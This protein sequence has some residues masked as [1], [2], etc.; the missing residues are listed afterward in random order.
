MR[1]LSASRKAWRS[2]AQKVGFMQKLCYL[3][4]CSWLFTGLARASSPTGEPLLAPLPHLEIPMVKS[5]ENR[6]VFRM[7][8]KAPSLLSKEETITV[9]RFSLPAADAELSALLAPESEAP[10]VVND[11]MN[12]ILNLTN[13]IT[14]EQVKEAKK[15]VDDAILV[16]NFVSSLNGDD[17]VTLPAVMKQEI[18]NLT[19]HLV[20]DKVTLKPQGACLN[21]IVGL[22]IPQKAYDAEGRKQEITLFFG[23]DDILI[24]QDGGIQGVSELKLL[25]DVAFELGGSTKKV[26]VQLVGEDNPNHSEYTYVS[27]GCSGI[28][29]FSLASNIFFSREWVVPLNEAG[30]VIPNQLVTAFFNLKVQDWNDILLQNLTINRFAMTDFSDVIIEVG[31]ANLDLSDYS[32]PSTLTFPDNYEPE[33]L[34]NPNLWRGVYIEHIE[35]TLPKPFKRKC[36]GFGSNGSGQTCRITLEAN[37]MIVDNTGFSAHLSIQN[38][39][40]ILGSGLM[41]GKWSWSLDQV[42]VEILQS[43]V[44][45]FGFGGEI[46]APITGKDT[47]IAYLG[48][49][50]F[51]SDNYHFVAT[52]GDDLEFP[53]FNAGQVTLYGGTVLEVS[54]TEEEFLPRMTI[55]GNITIGKAEDYNTSPQGSKAKLPGVEVLG[56]YVQTEE[57]YIG[58][59]PNGSISISAGEGKV[60]NF[61]VSVSDIDIGFPAPAPEGSE[62]AVSL[63]FNIGLN[64]MAPGDGGGMSASGDFRI[65]GKL[66]K[67]VNG[68]HQ[69]EFHE[70][71]FGGATVEIDKPQIK[72]C[73][74]L[75]LLE[76]DPVYGNGFYASVNMSILENDDVEPCG[77]LEGKFVLEMTALFGSNDGYRYFMVDGY[78]ESSDWSVPLP[79]TPFRMNGFGGGV[80]HHMK[81]VGY[82]D[83][84]LPPSVGVD[85]SGIK[86]E[87]NTSTKLGLKFVVGLTSNPSVNKSAMK[88]KLTCILRFGNNLSLQNITFWGVADFLVPDFEADVLPDINDRLASVFDLEDEMHAADKNKAQS[89]GDGKISMKVGLSFDFEDGFALHGY[90]EAHLKV[91]N[92]TFTGTGAVDILVDPGDDWHMYIGGY[93]DGTVQVP[94]FFGGPNEM[95][96]LYPLNISVNY[97]WINASADAYFLLGSDIPGPPPIH[98]AAAAYFENTTQEPGSNRGSEVMGCGGRGPANATG[99]AF[100]AGMQFSFKKKVKKFGVTILKMNVNGG[101]GFDVSVLQYPI[102]LTCSQYSMPAGSIQ[103][104]FGRRITGNIWAFVDAS[105]KVFGIPLPTLG[106]GV[107]LQADVPNPSYFEAIALLRVFNKKFK[108]PLELGNQ[109]GFPCSVI[110]P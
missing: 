58:M 100:G 9:Q 25:S 24:S 46:N 13:Y 86:Y 8:E 106:V 80:F 16:G 42:N 26:A 3:L 15:I 18:G 50:N 22:T 32:N 56:L 45:G 4:I 85:G 64:L 94:S 12:N 101:L 62:A 53:V 41:N 20:I 102:T 79:P 88:G 10:P 71:D 63:F 67:D 59:L 21:V 103:G 108:F 66:T 55:Y 84:S 30:S 98:P 90:A 61:P 38:G 23:A 87:P 81:P 73:G 28:Q 34:S 37:D 65:I 29:E 97:D 72:G 76:D 17:L 83:P 68:G 48:F 2:I 19:A 35:V 47:P 91:A 27:F 78:V 7:D 5:L 52:L 70:F 77:T 1:Y 105:G 57:P 93:H 96:T 104:I 109:C 40:S 6:P 31:N 54:A 43:S 36:D 11:E 49:F 69:W 107:F 99:F 110:E 82:V 14:S 89:V 44:V 51:V 33:E 74:V 60:M 95:I 39:A 92:G 75:K